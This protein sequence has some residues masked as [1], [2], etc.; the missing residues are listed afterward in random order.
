MES[1]QGQVRLIKTTF[2]LSEYVKRL[3]EEKSKK[4]KTASFLVELK[5]AKSE[6]DTIKRNLNLITDLDAKEYCIY[7]LKAAELNL[8]RYMKQAKAVHAFSAPLWEESV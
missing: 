5:S 2:K 7:R 3:K 8:N 4:Q 6:V 1:V